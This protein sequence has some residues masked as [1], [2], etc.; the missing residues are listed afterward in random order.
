MSEL[1]LRTDQVLRFV[2]V[3]RDAVLVV[4]GVDARLEREDVGSDTSQ[5]HIFL[6]SLIEGLPQLGARL[7]GPVLICLSNDEFTGV[8]VVAVCSSW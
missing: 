1:A 5:D 4:D 8:R 3:Y 2:K 7:L 6:C